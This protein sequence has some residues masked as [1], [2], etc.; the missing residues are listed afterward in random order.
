MSLLYQSNL[1]A[2]VSQS[3]GPV[4]NL[5]RTPPSATAQ[6]VLV[7][8]AE[9]SAGPYRLTRGDST[10]DDWYPIPFQSPFPVVHLEAF[11][12]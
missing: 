8:S 1:T 12:T 10:I 2:V 11:N 7:S 9:S 4:R 3:L 6:V 5:N